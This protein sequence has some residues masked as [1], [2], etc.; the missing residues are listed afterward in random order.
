M[1]SR[2]MC[3]LLDDYRNKKNTS[4]IKFTDGIVS[5]RQYKRYLYGTSEMPFKMFVELCDRIQLDPTFLVYDLERKRI[6]QLNRLDEFSNAIIYHDY[7]KAESMILDFK[8]ETFLDKMNAI[9]F[10]LTILQMDLYLKKYPNAYYGNE[11]ARLINYP[12]I[13]NYNMM[14]GVEL[15]GLAMLIEFVSGDEKR[16]IMDKL[17]QIITTKSYSFLAKDFYNLSYV[18]LKVAKE[19]GREKEFQKVIEICNLVLKDTD[20]FNSY[21]NLDHLYYYMCLAYRGLNDME[22]AHY[23]IEQLYYAIKIQRD[24]AILT[25]YNRLIT[26]DFGFNF[27][28]L[29]A[30]QKKY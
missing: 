9:Y 7:E 5:L 18:R 26:K 29:F 6:E 24:D 15:S 1:I 23:Y 28:E 4:M 17:N 19:F 11:I 30:N 16:V 8:K 21:F 2:E 22:K 10:E 13:L 27:E 20:K 3:I 14:N 25:K 12:E